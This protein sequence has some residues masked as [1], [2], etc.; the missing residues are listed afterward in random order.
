MHP[1]RTEIGP[2]TRLA[3]PIVLAEL[4]WM[5]MSLADTVMVGR[6]GAAA[7]GAVG[8]GASLFYTV[9]IF[10]TGLLL[11][12]DTT[13][14]QA[15]G[16]GDRDECRRSLMAGLWLIL[17]L[18]PL[19]VGMTWLFVPLV[20]LFG[21]Q[22][23]V[24]KNTVPYLFA[25]SWSAIPLLVFFALR[26]YL[27]SMNLVR[28]VMFALISANLVNIAVN[29]ILIFGHFGA[30]ALGAEGAGW[31]TTLSRLYMA[32]VLVVYA[33]VQDPALMR[34]RLAPDFARIRRLFALGFPAAAQFSLEVG[35]FAAVTA[36]IAKL[37]EISLAAHQIAL[38]TVSFTYMVPLGIS[39]AGAVRVGHAVGRRDAAAAGVSGWTAM[40]L[41]AGFMGCA[42]LALLC[43]PHMLSRIFTN[44]AEVSAAAVPLLAVAAAFQLFDGLQ[45]VGTGILRGL[46]DTRTTMVAHIGCYWFIGLPLGSWLCFRKHWGAVGLWTGLSAAL[47]LIGCVALT[48]WIY[49]LRGFRRVVVN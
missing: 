30:P 20:R 34:V 43:A 22:P 40:A 45:T 38:L 24:L 46:G 10:G 9:A 31:A 35:V 47:I 12:L 28:V 2:M 15:F 32:L 11:G 17:P 48:G 29:W 14:S 18:A 27:Q 25:I 16:A 37:D 6:V 4:G 7:M 21:V 13:V 8:L 3:V 5:T 41:G 23:A 1:F 44:Q 33:V 42:A 26:R 49:R 19:L 39:S 36:L